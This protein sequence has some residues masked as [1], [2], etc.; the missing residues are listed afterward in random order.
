VNCYKVE[1]LPDHGLN[2][3]LIGI[4]ANVA[5]KYI[6]NLVSLSAGLRTPS[7]KTENMR[8]PR[9]STRKAMAQVLNQHAVVWSEDLD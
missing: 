8:G 4:K 6:D 7:E 2:L 5:S 1:Q 9:L 3:R